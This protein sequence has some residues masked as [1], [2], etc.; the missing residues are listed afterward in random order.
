MTVPLH[1]LDI[2]RQPA[3]ILD[4]AGRIEVAND[5]AEAM[6][7]RPL[8]GLSAP[9]T[10]RVFACRRPDGVL[11]EPA[12]PAV[13]PGAR[14][15]G[16]S[17]GAARGDRSGRP[18]P[19][20]AGHGLA[21]RRGGR[22]RRG[23]RRLAGRD[24]A[25]PGRGSPASERGATQGR[26]RALPRRGVPHRSPRQ[27]LRLHQPGQRDPDRFLRR[28]V[29]CVRPRRVPGPD[30]RRGPA[31]GQDDHRGGDAGAPCR[32]ERHGRVP[33][34][35]PGRELALALGP[36]RLPDGPVGPAPL[37]RRGGPGRH[38][39]ARDRGRAPGRRGAAPARAGGGADRNLG[40]GGRH[41]PGDH[42]AELPPHVRARG[43]GDLRATRTSSG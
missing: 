9:E 41:E 15:R 14:G 17:R 10:A 11:L 43:D 38:A 40:L 1:T 28:G 34:P 21:D 25:R 30:P 5:L 19:H 42:L 27:P 22:G 2:V 8:A 4:A 23:P 6:A 13:V 39:A 35:A 33:V 12:E 3:F 36:L 31:E 20:R 24:R 7:G 16:G 26:A 29:R 18:D 37:P 32:D